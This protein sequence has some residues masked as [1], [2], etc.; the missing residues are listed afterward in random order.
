MQI[1]KINLLNPNFKFRKPFS[2]LSPAKVNF[3][4]QDT[5]TKSGDYSNET[6]R[7]LLKSKLAENMTQED[8][9]VCMRN[10]AEISQE[11]GIELI[12]LPIDESHPGSL[13]NE[14]RKQ[15]FLRVKDYIFS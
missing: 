7:E 9:D 14:Q 2:N 8:V 6:A 1:S 4:S 3:T 12:N 5:F 15:F 10:L 13:T 11:L